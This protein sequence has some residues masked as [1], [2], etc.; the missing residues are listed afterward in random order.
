MKR[1][2][3]NLTEEQ[4]QKLDKLISINQWIVI[5]A[6][7]YNLKAKPTQ[8][9]KYSNNYTENNEVMCYFELQFECFD[10]MFYSETK[11]I[12]LATVNKMFYF[13]LEIPEESG[14]VF[15]EIQKRKGSNLKND[16]TRARNRLMSGFSIGYASAFCSCAGSSTGLLRTM[17]S[18]RLMGVPILWNFAS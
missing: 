2:N 14:V 12:E 13:P 5:K 16:R 1:I 3:Y 11:Y 10:P 17:H 4:K 15:G 8:P 7:G 9:P 18:T 6:N